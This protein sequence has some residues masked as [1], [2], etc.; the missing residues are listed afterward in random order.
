M[1]LIYYIED[2]ESIAYG[3]STY[4][5]GKGFEVQII[6]NVADAKQLMKKRVPCLCLIDWNLPDGSGE[7]L[8]QWIRKER[9]ELPVIFITVKGEIRDI[10][11]GFNNGADDYIVKP[12]ELEVLL[13]RITALLRR[14]RKVQENYLTCG[15]IALDKTKYQVFY[16]QKEVILSSMEYQLLLILMENQNH[17]ITR[18]RLLE[19]IWDA[20]GNYVNDNTLTVTMKRLREKLHNP[21]CIKTIRSFGYRM[22]E[23]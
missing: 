22:E 7:Q 13:S 10:V 1:N 18:Q 20:N 15:D 11:Q 3:V 19:V 6:E 16:K 14:T 23:A 2:D 9:A 5:Q 17:T 8:C 21:S 4:L 12:F